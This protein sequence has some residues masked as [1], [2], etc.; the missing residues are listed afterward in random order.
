M[1]EEVED[2]VCAV[3]SLAVRGL[4]VSGLER[5]EDEVEG[6]EEGK[7]ALLV[8]VL[9]WTAPGWSEGDGGAEDGSARG[10][11]SEATRKVKVP[12]DSQRLEALERLVGRVRKGGISV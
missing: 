7:G 3:R 8:G 1:R 10:P 12:A 4:A 6:E 5:D 2:R 9:C 11:G